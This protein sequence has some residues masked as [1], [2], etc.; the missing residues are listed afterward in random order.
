MGLKPRLGLCLARF[1]A[2]R[3]NVIHLSFHLHLIIVF[4]IFELLEIVK[5][6]Q[7]VGPSQGLVKEVLVEDFQ[8]LQLELRA[9]V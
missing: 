2:F 1:F 3:S 9:T 5:P 4:A 6:S 8:T 7:F